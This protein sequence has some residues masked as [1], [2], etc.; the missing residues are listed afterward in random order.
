MIST[1]YS[2]TEIVVND[3]IV[4]LLTTISDSSNPVTSSVKVIVA[5]NGAFVGLFAVVVIDTSGLVKSY[6]TE[7]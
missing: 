5:V 1:V 7:N 2:E 4:A 6:S 3:P